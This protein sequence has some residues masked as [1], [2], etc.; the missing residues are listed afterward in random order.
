MCLSKNSVVRIKFIKVSKN[1]NF[2]KKLFRN[3]AFKIHKSNLYSNNQHI[4]HLFQFSFPVVILFFKSIP[5]FFHGKMMIG[6][7]NFFL[8]LVLE[9]F[10]FRSAKLVSI[11]IG[12]K[13]NDVSFIQ[14]N[15]ILF[16]GIHS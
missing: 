13:I 16:K 12:K 7:N 9:F 14:L 3:C 2:F 8:L 5:L 6:K 1:Y 15:R 11:A 10:S 4:I